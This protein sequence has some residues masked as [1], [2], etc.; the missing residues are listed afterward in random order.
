VKRSILIWG[1][2]VLVAVV[3]VQPAAAMGKPR[4]AALQVGLSAKG[5]Y[6]GTIDGILG[7]GT[8]RAVRRLQRNARIT[9]DGIPG[10]QT[11]KALGRLGRHDFGSRIL[12]RGYVGWDVSMTQFLLAWHGFPSGPFDGGYGPRTQSAVRLFQRWAKIGVDGR[13]GAATYRALR[14]PLPRPG[15]SLS[16][17]VGIGA[18]DRFGPRGNRFH[19]GLDFPSGYGARVRSAAAGVVVSAG[20]DSGGFGNLVVVRHRNGR[21]TWYAHLSQ[22]A[23]GAGQHVGR[24]RVVGRVGATGSAT[25][26]HL[27]FELRVRGA[28]VNPLPAFR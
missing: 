3:A 1:V 2:A 18:T 8:K 16:R 4:V 15:I 21:A 20:W 10:P 22:F 9:V 26:P 28:A 13:A 6:G 14:G 19:T 12:R 24:G 5:L 25:G 7:P 23:V 27:H 11:R 17:P